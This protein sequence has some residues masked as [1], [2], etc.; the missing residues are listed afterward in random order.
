MYSPVTSDTMQSKVSAVPYSQHKIL[1]LL[2]RAL[3]FRARTSDRPRGHPS[4]RVSILPAVS[5]EAV[6]DGWLHSEDTSSIQ[7]ERSQALTAVL[8]KNRVFRDVTPCGLARQ[9]PT[10]R[11]NVLPSNPESS[12]LH[13]LPHPNTLKY[14]TF[15]NIYTTGTRPF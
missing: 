15:Q 4:F 2:Q 14:S 1:K 13:N 3:D 6:T 9:I 11:R 5:Q 10:F 12:S 7:K 8:L